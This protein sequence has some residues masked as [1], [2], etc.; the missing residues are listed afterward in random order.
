MISKSNKLKICTILG[1]DII[2]L[3]TQLA[4]YSDYIDSETETAIA[5]EIARWDAG[6]GTDFVSLEPKE[7]N[8]G[9]RTSAS[10]EKDD[11][12]QNLAVLLMASDWA[13]ASGSIQFEIERG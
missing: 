8:K 2:Q 4:A 11:I 7:S 1:V 6:A 9:V 3:D 13:S 12:R 5:A 10:L